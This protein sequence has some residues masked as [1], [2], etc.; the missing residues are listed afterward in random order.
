[1][2]KLLRYSLLAMTICL[3][4]LCS[5]FA[6]AQSNGGYV[7]TGSL[8]NAY[9]QRGTY[10]AHQHRAMRH[11]RHRRHGHHHHVAA[12]IKIRL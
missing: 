10:A 6:F 2:N 11:H 8:T 1:M 12:A 4:V 7:H 3:A 5:T 9:G